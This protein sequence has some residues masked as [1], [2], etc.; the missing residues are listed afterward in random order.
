MKSLQK[1]QALLTTHAD[2]F[3]I[4]HWKACGHNFDSAHKIAE[5]YY[6]MLSNDIDDVAEIMIR[7]DINP[8]NMISCVKLSLEY[9]TIKDTVKPSN[10]YDKYD[11]VEISD[12]ILEELCSIIKDTIQDFQDEDSIGVKS[13]LESLFEKY[14]KEYRY[15]NRRRSI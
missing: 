14:D 12:S 7:Y 5:N 10:N 1:L 13:Y 8:L 2:N 6:E 11:I 3:R 9:N 4:L 15:I